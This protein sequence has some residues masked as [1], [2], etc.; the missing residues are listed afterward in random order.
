M[1]VE[2]LSKKKSTESYF[3]LLIDI[4]HSLNKNANTMF[5]DNA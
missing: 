4:L 5:E 3:I 2:L 1:K